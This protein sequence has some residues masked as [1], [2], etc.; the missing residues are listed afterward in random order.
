MQNN[1]SNDKDQNN[2]PEQKFDSH[3]NE[4]VVS[5]DWDTNQYTTE[6]GKKHQLNSEKTPDGT[7]KAD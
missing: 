2:T 7:K 6:S 4:Q 3:D 5:I 1:P